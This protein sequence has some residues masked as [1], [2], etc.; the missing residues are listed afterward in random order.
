MS[1]FEP[2]PA[3]EYD[4]RDILYAKDDWVARVTLNRPQAYNAYSTPALRELATAFRDA[5]FDDSVAVVVYTGAG[6]D[7]FCTGGDVKEY[8][9][10]YTDRPRDYWKY[11]QLFRSYLESILRCGKPVIARLNG[12]AVGGG[13]ESQMACDL[14]VI[15]EHAWIGQ[16]GTR[17]GSV[18]AGGATQWLP[19]IVGDRRAREIL[20]LNERISPRQALEWGLVN[21]VVP[22]VVRD[23]AFVEGATLQEIEKARKG[24]DGYSLSLE[25]LDRAVDDLA[26]RLVEK[27]AE[28][29]R[30]TREQVNFWKELAW[31]QT[32][33]A[34]GDWLSVHYSSY[35][36]WEGMRAFVEK[37]PPRYRELREL[38]ASGGSSEFVWGP[39]RARCPACG[40]EGIPAGFDYC[41]ACGA[42]L[43]AAPG[44][45]GPASGA[46]RHGAAAGAGATEGS[47]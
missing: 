11:M 37:R 40:A 42:A 4:F 17:V 31:N 46:G 36:P 29:T 44:N 14:A 35:E 13:N 22:S 18:A 2:R 38:A 41:G 28:C 26:G 24:E 47:R 15:A 34:A 45:G 20:M 1:H 33:G 23:G 5:A 19:I 12:M 43:E 39:Y 25:A 3:A 30:F 8:E 10:L 16:V 21:R 7:A 32:I 9:R 27:F 6:T